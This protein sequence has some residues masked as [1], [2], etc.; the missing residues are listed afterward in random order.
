VLI[1]ALGLWATLSSLWSVIPQHSFLEGIRLFALSAGGLFILGSGLSVTQENRIHI[2]KA[3]LVGL[4]LALI[5]LAIERFAHQP[6]TRWWYHIT[7][8]YLPLA[9]Y[10]RGV[11]VI[12][13]AGWA[14]IVAQETVWRQFALVV[15]FLAT[16]FL[17]VSE[18]AMLA[19]IAGTTTFIAARFVPR[20]V[21]GA[22]IAGTLILGVA[23]PVATPS[24]ETVLWLH[25]N[26]HQI[27]P[28]GIHRLL[29]WRFG[30]DRVAE[31]PFLGWGMDASRAIPGGQTDLNVM[32]PGLHYGEPAQALPLHPHDAALQWQL[33]L[34]LPG[35][36][37]GLGIV[38]WIIYAIGWRARLT[39]TQRAGALALTMA[40]LTIGLLSFGIWQ[41]W[42]LSTLWIC[43]AL[44]AATTGEVADDTKVL[45]A[46]H[47]AS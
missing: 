22:M 31:R 19:A 8:N 1:A 44:F 21:A 41:A 26:V 43:A 38:V 28:S 27:K 46:D 47:P 16:A 9:R 30:A 7:D 35:L 6:V 15:L 5:L 13:L 17:M 39:P 20:F 23:I 24:N 3:L 29:I 34:G 2:N 10:D 37:L 14:A 25:D 42:W 32:L 4:S 18:A 36:A 33:E 45:T 11:V 12:A 40:A